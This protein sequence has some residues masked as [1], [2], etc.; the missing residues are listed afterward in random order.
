MIDRVEELRQRAEDARAEIVKFSNL[1]ET[2]GWKELVTVLK[3]QIKSRDQLNP[4]ESFDDMIRGNTLMAEGRG[5]HM[6]ILLPKQL[7]EAAEEELELI[8][9]ELQDLT[10][11]EDNGNE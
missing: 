2:A 8:N 7:I 6:A 3:A 11:D 5:I 10:E 4:A 9:Q 1:Q